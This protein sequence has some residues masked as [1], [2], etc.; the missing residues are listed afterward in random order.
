MGNVSI[1]ESL[2][3]KLLDLYELILDIKSYPHFLSWF[4]EVLIINSH[5]QKSQDSYSIGTIEA[6][7]RIGFGPL[8]T[9]YIS[10]INHRLLEVNG[11][12]KE[13]KVTITSSSSI[14]KEMYNEWSL[15]YVDDYCTKIEFCSKTVLSSRIFSHLLEKKIN[16]QSIKILNKFKE[17]A[18][19]LFSKE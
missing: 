11:V 9:T 10:N 6:K 16:A 4:K 3:F 2:P 1:C 18:G 8:F 14:F 17:R 13:A 19:D 12:S 15:E 5:N 7:V